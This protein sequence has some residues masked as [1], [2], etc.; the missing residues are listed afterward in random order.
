MNPE[1]IAELDAKI[2]KYADRLNRLKKERR[3]RRAIRKKSERPQGRPKVAEEKIYIAANLVANGVAVRTA[4][5]KAGIS[6]TTAFRRG[7]TREKIER[8]MAASS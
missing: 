6:P 7:I 5:L 4:C 1:K 8:R 2:R 3:K